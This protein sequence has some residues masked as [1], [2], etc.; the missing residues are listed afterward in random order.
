MDTSAVNWTQVIISLLSS[1]GIAAVLT[2]VIQWRNITA[3]NKVQGAAQVI[4][5]F[6]KLVR[7][8]LAQIDMNNREIACL[9]GRID[10]LTKLYDNDRAAWARERQ[11]LEQR[12]ADLEGQNARLEEQLDRLSNRR[13]R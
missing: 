11:E 13:K 4:D 1:G 5:G 9:R 3:T 7:S 8:L 6:D 12:I 10:E 2:S